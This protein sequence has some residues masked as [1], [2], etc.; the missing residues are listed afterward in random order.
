MYPFVNSGFTYSDSCNGQQ[1]LFTNTSSSSSGKINSALW[2]IE[3]DSTVL[4]SSDQSNIKYIFQK[5]PQTY[6]VTLTVSNDKGC[7]ATDTKY[8]NISRSPS[9]LVS[10]DTILARGATLQLEADDGNFSSGGSFYWWPSFGLND[11]SIAD[12]LLTS[13]TDTTYHVFIKNRFGC[14]LQDSIEVKYYT[15]PDIYV[16][17]AFTPNGD[18]RNDIFRA[19]PVGISKMDYFR[20]YNRNG[21]LVFQTS[22]AAHGWDGTIRGIP[23]AEGTYVWEVRGVDYS[24][25][26]I[27]K[28]GTVVL[29]R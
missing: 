9:Q 17:N 4:Y 14:A 25:K 18:G 28:K 19:V 6:S 3:E 27:S 11:I 22:Q 1:I 10:H 26:T 2:K 13:T 7:V 12:P 24:G 15:G 5:S 16:P 21:Q 23:S 29:V 20:V 8:I